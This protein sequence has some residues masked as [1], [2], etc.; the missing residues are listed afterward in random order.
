MDEVWKW[1][2]R[3]GC[4]EEGKGN[5]FNREKDYRGKKILS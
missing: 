3:N 5:W 2:L 4:W 1:N